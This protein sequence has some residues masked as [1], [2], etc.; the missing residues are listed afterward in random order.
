MPPH[1]VPPVPFAVIRDDVVAAHD[2]PPAAGAIDEGH[3]NALLRDARLARLSQIVTVNNNHSEAY[4]R[5]EVRNSKR[6]ESFGGQPLTGQELLEALGKANKNH[7]QSVAAA[8]SST[9]YNNHPNPAFNWELSKWEDREHLLADA[10]K[11]SNKVH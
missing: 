4:N 8:I 6:F 11:V 3:G 9:G 7:P 5:Q 10:I 2:N 1:L